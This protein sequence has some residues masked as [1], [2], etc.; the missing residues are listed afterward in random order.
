LFHLVYF[1]YSLRKTDCYLRDALFGQCLR[2]SREN[3]TVMIRIERGADSA[4]RAKVADVGGVVEGQVRSSDAYLVNLPL[5][6]AV[7]VTR[8]QYVLKMSLGPTFGVTK[9][10][11]TAKL[12]WQ[13]A[14]KS[15]DH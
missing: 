11:S 5:H 1:S 9:H 6:A 14:C 13:V 4:F 8:M 2:G 12:E 10:T 3:I 7:R 15:L